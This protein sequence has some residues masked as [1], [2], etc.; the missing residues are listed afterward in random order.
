MKGFIKPDADVV[1]G[2]YQ[3]GIKFGEEGGIHGFYKPFFGV[4]LH[5][6][7]IGF[8]LMPPAY[9]RIRRAPNPHWTFGLR[10]GNKRWGK[11]RFV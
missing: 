9:M 7:Q 11:A 8:Y 4:R 5:I 2:F 10:I 6:K 3:W 1:C